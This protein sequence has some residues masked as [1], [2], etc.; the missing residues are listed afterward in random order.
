MS[1]STTSIPSHDSHNTTSLD[2]LGKFSLPPYADIILRSRDSHD[3]RVQKLYVID[4][5]P[6]LAERIAAT[7]CDD[8]K[9]EATGNGEILLPVVQLPESHEIISSLLSFVFPVP[10]V[11]PPGIEEIIDL[12]SL[13]QEYQATTALTR[14]RDCVRHDPKFVYSENALYVYEL[15]WKHGL[16]EEALLAAEDLLKRPM[17]IPEFEID[18]AGIPGAALG[19]LW[20]YRKRV[21]EN[22]IQNLGPDSDFY[23]YQS[24]NVLNCV[25]MSQNNIPLWLDL[26]LDSV[27]EDPACLDITTFHLTLSAHISHPDTS[28]DYCK[29]CKSIP[30]ETIRK[31]WVA[32]MAVFRDSIRKAES[33]F[34]LTQKSTSETTGALPLLEGLNMQGADV[35][36]Q[37]SDLISFRVHKSTMAISSPFFSDLFSL[38]QPPNGEVIDGLPV[39][40]VSED[41]EVLHSLLTRLYPIPSVIPDSYEKALALL[42]ASREYDMDTISSAVR[43]EICLPTT[44]EAFRAYA[45]ASSK[46]LI[47]EMRTAAHLTLDHPMTFE[48][49]ADALP[50][51]K[52]P[53]L[54][55]LIRFRKRCHSNLLSFFVDFVDGDDN[56]SRAW[57]NCR[58]TKRPFS[59][60]QSDKGV[61]AGWFRDLVDQHIKSLQETYACPL[62]TS[63]SL[64]KEFTLALRAHISGTQCSSCSNLYATDG[65]TLRDKWLRGVSKARDKTPFR[66]TGTPN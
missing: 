21:L 7:I 36:L 9:P 10:P 39:V 37:S 6:V 23:I 14:I 50:L 65:E 27:T 16:L 29:H 12:L 33:D 32:L 54:Q 41:A 51:F 4:C 5:S 18:L 20:A 24:S 49:I 34:S 60:L 63:S 66:H 28:S 17:T 55:D 45:I 62:P 15:A 57:N 22:V 35:I 48:T 61:L 11:L 52:G 30:G 64:R 40:R 1:E 53:A 56:L 31:F 58:K 2:F 13:A 43:C 59:S 19:E 44:K 38:P 47:P 25:E 42:A 46:N 3:F 26:Y 8:V